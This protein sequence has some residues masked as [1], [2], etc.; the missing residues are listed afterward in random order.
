MIRCL[1]VVRSIENRRKNKIDRVA[2]EI[3]FEYESPTTT[4]TASPYAAYSQWGQYS[5]AKALQ[6]TSSG[7]QPQHSKSLVQQQQQ[8]QLLQQRPP[9]VNQM[10]RQRLQRQ[11]QQNLQTPGSMSPQGE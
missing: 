7:S 11:Q 5:A 9:N 6:S 1:T 10:I 4:T 3:E 2:G 8:Q